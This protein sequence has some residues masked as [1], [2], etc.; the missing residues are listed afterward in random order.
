MALLLGVAERRASGAMGGGSAVETVK[1]AVRVGAQVV[2]QPT[3]S[4]IAQTIAVT[5]L[6]WDVEPTALMVSCSPES[7]KEEEGARVAHLSTPSPQL[8]GSPGIPEAAQVSH[9]Q[10]RRLYQ[11]VHRG[12]SP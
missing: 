6:R 1:A 2:V 9:V 4:S 11:R 8:Q 12:A 3:A 5:S 7:R 10:D